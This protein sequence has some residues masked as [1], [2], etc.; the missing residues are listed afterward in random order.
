MERDGDAKIVAVLKS[1]V[2]DD[3]FHSSIISC[4]FDFATSL[5]PSI[6]FEID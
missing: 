2:E 5:I 1:L 4:C 3:P 6:N